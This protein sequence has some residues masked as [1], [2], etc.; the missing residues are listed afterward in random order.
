MRRASI[1]VAAFCPWRH[2][3]GRTERRRHQGA[4]EH[5]KAGRRAVKPVGA[6]Y[7]GEADF[8]LAKVQAALKVIQ[9]KALLP[10]LF[11]EDLKDRKRYR[12]PSDHLGREGGLRS[13][14]QRSSA[15]QAKAARSID[16]LDEGDVPRR[17]PGREVMKATAAAAMQKFRGDVVCCSTRMA[18]F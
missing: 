12:G 2:S 5:M 17:P 4:P 9:E 16:H 13:R 8:D 7:K 15:K 18:L 11:P 14:F 6:M 10:P 3:G 1:I